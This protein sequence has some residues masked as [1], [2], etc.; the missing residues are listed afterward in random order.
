[1]SSETRG[2]THRSVSEG[3]VHVLHVDDD[4]A[5]AGLVDHWLTRR[6]LKVVT[7]GSA[8]EMRS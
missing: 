3:P 1:M 4:S 7:L 5:W 8:V 6:G 2:L